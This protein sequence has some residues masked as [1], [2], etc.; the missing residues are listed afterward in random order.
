M[1]VK[2]DL[3]KEIDKFQE[4]TGLSDRDIGSFSKGAPCFVYNLRNPNK[5]INSKSIDQLYK[6][7]SEYT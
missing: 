7:L 5:A 6:F 2:E 1:G 4:R 3:I